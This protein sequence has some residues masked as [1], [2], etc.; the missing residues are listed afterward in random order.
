[1]ATYKV[2]LNSILTQM[3][4]LKLLIHLKDFHDMRQMS[5]PGFVSSSGTMSG[6]TASNASSRVRHV[7]AT[8]HSLGNFPER[9]YLRAVFSHIPAFAAANDKSVSVFTCFISIL[10]CW[11]FTIYPSMLQKVRHYRTP[12]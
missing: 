1:M 9:T 8:A 12:R 4:L 10:T 11:S 3:I 6:H 2:S 5:R 7:C